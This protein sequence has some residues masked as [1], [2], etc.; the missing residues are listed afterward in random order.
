MKKILGATLLTAVAG[1][2]FVVSSAMAVDMKLPQKGEEFLGVD[3]APVQI[4]EYASATCGHCGDFH[5]KTLPEIKEKY[6]DT[7]KVK[8]V[9]RDLPWDNRAFAVSTIAR[10]S[11]DYYSFMSA[12]MSTQASWVASKD[13]MGA[14][15]Q[16]AR[17]GGMDGEKITECLSD[18]TITSKITEGRGVAEKLGV[19]GTPSFFIN[20]E[21]HPGALTVKKMSDIIDAELAK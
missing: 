18:E 15:K 10:C 16:V 17:L 14:I 3:N 1:V 8:F 2:A 13:F 9:L 7:G 21:L 5:T 11:G 12:F 4:V 19:T 20:G 6:I